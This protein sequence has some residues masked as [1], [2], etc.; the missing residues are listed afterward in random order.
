M[1]KRRIYYRKKKG[2][3]IIEGKSGGKT[4]YI[5][6]LPKPEKLLDALEPENERQNHSTKVSLRI[7][8]KSSFLT[9]EKWL[10]IVKK[11]YRLD[12]KQSLG[13]KPS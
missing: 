8:K 3:I 10:E 13:S 2:H 9:R 12:Y 4:I 7:Q 6:T 11:V 1:K 5:L